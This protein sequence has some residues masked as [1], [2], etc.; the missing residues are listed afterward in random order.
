MECINLKDL[1]GDRYKVTFEESHAAEHG[2]DGWTP[3]PWLMVI[4]CRRGE[5]CPWGGDMLAACTNS[6]QMANKI[7]GLPFA[8]MLQDGDDG[9]NVGFPVDHFEAVAKIMRP[10]R[11]PQL[12]PERRA[13]LAE[14]MRR[15]N[16]TPRKNGPQIAPECVSSTCLV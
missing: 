11:R 14:A 10:H 8:E 2:S 6:R 1:F 9:G 12:S 15:I 16:E 4:R 7:A 3:D 13:E 5:I